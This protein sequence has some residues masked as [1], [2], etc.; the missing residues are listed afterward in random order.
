MLTEVG[1]ARQG[2]SDGH[3]KEAELDNNIAEDEKREIQLLF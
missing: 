3:S 1:C 2:E